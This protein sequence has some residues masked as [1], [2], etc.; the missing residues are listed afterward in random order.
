M[1]KDKKK[2]GKGAEKAQ[3]RFHCWSQ[4][5]GGLKSQSAP[6]Q[7]S[8]GPARRSLGYSRCHFHFETVLKGK[9]V[10]K[11]NKK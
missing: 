2:K 7:L 8:E 9:S 1:G 4:E 6:T 5:I 10:E 11:S 3:V